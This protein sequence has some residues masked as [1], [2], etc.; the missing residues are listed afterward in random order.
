MNFVTLYLDEVC[1]DGSS[2]TFPMLPYHLVAQAAARTATAIDIY[3]ELHQS[4]IPPVQLAEIFLQFEGDV[5]RSL[6]F[7]PS[8]LSC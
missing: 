3:E 8:A 7:S 5:V 2:D 4:G 6:V 1:F